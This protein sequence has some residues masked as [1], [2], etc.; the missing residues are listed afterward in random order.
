VTTHPRLLNPQAKK[1]AS[2]VRA[3]VLIGVTAVF[4]AAFTPHMTRPSVA[5]KLA[6]INHPDACPPQWVSVLLASS[7]SHV[8]SPAHRFDEEDLPFER[9]MSEI[10]PDCGSEA[11]LVAVWACHVECKIVYFDANCENKECL[12]CKKECQG[13]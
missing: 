8:D 12:N 4:C 6:K 13:N 1:D 7:S 5:S 10:D 11:Y 9:R 3:L 2:R